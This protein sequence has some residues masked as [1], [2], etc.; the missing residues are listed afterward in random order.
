[1]SLNSNQAMT[2]LAGEAGPL[3]S[4]SAGARGA[5]ALKPSDI[6]FEQAASLN[7]AGITALQ[8]CATKERFS[9]GRKS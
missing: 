7:I 1:M 3:P 2:C 8:G 9:R 5:V 6:S 4:M